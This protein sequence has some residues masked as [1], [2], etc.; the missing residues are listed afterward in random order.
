MS[1]SLTRDEFCQRLFDRAELL[2]IAIKE[3]ISKIN[4]VTTAQVQLSS[5]QHE[6]HINNDITQPILELIMKEMN[7]IIDLVYNEGLD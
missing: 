4:F 7:R 1:I 2:G 6:I 5:S 3:D